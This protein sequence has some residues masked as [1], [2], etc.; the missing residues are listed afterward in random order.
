VYIYFHTQRD[1]V[2]ALVLDL[3]ALCLNSIL[4]ISPSV[5]PQ[6]HRFL[7]ALYYHECG[8]RERASP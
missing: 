1:H 2:L 4:V 6:P 7:D 5:D 3:D 8:L